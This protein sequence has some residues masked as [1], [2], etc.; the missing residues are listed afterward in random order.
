MQIEQAFYG[1]ARGAHSLL[2]SSRDDEVSAEIVQRLDL[3]DTAPPRAEWSPFLRGFPHR[4]RYV[5]ARTFR[6]T[7]ASRGGMVFSHALLTPLEEIGETADLGPLL[8]RLATS[9]RQRPRVETV[10]T[11]QAEKGTPEA[12][13]PVRRSRSSFDESSV[14]GRTPRPSGIRRSCGCVVGPPLTRDPTGIRFPFEFR[15]SGSRR[16]AATDACLYAARHG[17]AVVRTPDCSFTRS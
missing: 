10:P 16:G 5:L 11:V 8:A 13:D 3:P 2:A 1:D 14:A 6:D 17:G 12:A 4:D 9:H 7:G 15:P